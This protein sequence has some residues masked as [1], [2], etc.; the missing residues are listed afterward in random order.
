M[1]N[2]FVIIGAGIFGVEL[3]LKLSEKNFKVT[4]IE[5]ENQILSH[6]SKMN[7]NRVHLGFHYPRCLKTAKQA[8]ESYGYFTS[9]FKN[10][11]RPSM[12]SFYMI[13]NEPSRNINI[14]EYVSFCSKLNLEYKTV[15]KSFFNK[16]LNIDK[17]EDDVFLVLCTVFKFDFL[18]IIIIIIAPI[19]LNKAMITMSVKIK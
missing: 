10:A 14:N 1:N 8:I 7:Q 2:D 17:I 6:A 18:S 19:T 5:K 11:I 15:N 13:S 9:R 3:A 4:L 16:Y 12:R